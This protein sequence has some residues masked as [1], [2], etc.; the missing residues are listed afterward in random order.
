MESLVGQGFIEETIRGETLK[1][2]I[3]KIMTLACEDAPEWAGSCCLP[4]DV[5]EHVCL[6]L[7]SLSQEATSKPVKD[8]IAVAEFL[9]GTQSSFSLSL[10]CLTC[11]EFV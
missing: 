7:C 1:H 4:L 9:S 5:F 10:C 8:E 2:V 6:L 11:V 3:T